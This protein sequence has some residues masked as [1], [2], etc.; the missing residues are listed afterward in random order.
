MCN[1]KLFL[2]TTK[3]LSS[4]FVIVML[5][6]SVTRGQEAPTPRTDVFADRPR[7]DVATSIT[8]EEARMIIEA[9]NRCGP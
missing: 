2:T 8:L 6:A 9:A 3:K 7:I 1:R 4:V 5:G